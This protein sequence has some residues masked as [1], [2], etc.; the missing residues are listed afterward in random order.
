MLRI[1]R[2]TVTRETVRSRG[3]ATGGRMRE[4]ATTGPKAIAPGRGTSISS[5]ARNWNKHGGNSKKPAGDWRIWNGALAAP[6]ARQRAVVAIGFPEAAAKPLTEG[7]ARPAV[8]LPVARGPALVARKV[9]CRPVASRDSCRNLPLAPPALAAAAL[10]V[11]FRVARCPL[12]LALP[13]WPVPAAAVAA[14]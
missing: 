12:A 4:H 13:R 5:Y 6:V 10:Q 11:D 2:E 7:P 8:T 1:G 9:R 3:P 14:A